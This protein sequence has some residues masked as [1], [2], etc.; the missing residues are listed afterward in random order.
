MYLGGCFSDFFSPICLLCS[1]AHVTPQSPNFWCF[2][3]YC[4][5]YVCEKQLHIPRASES[6]QKGHNH[7]WEEGTPFLLLIFSAGSAGGGVDH[8]IWGGLWR[9]HP[10]VQMDHWGGL[11]VLTWRKVSIPALWRGFW[12]I[13][14]PLNSDS[15]LTSQS[16]FLTDRFHFFKSFIYSD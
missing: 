2:T 12:L 5:Q 15:H 1:F 7:D 3:I 6:L 9:Q 10:A 13:R 11:Q 14:D 16:P 4:H 8:V